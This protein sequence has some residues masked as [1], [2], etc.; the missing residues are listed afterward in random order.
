MP[1]LRFKAGTAPTDLAIGE[2]TVRTIKDGDHTSPWLWFCVRQFDGE[3]LLSGVPINIGGEAAGKAWGF[4]RTGAGVWQ[5]SPSIAVSR[6]EHEGR[7]RVE[8]WHETPAVV[9]VPEPPPWGK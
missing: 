9:G 8:L 7:P 1:A 3:K 5:V 6:P 4:R 2:C